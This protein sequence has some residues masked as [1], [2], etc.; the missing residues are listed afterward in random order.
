MLGKSQ[1][2]KF[3]L[4]SLRLKDCDLSFWYLQPFESIF[5]ELLE[6]QS[7]IMDWIWC[8]N[9]DPVYQTTAMSLLNF[10]KGLRQ[11]CGNITPVAMNNLHFTFFAKLTQ[12]RCNVLTLKSR[13]R[14]EFDVVVTLYRRCH[15]SIH[16]LL[17][18]EFTIQSWGKVETTW[19]QCCEFYV[20]STL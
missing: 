1:A 5:W 19:I 2:G 18:G 12:R 13:R 3:F 8:H 14:C 17:W 16:D 15:Y 10:S 7:E 9:I 20:V 4:Q 11:G 6:Y